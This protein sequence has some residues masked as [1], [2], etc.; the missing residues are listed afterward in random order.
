MLA[1]LGAVRRQDERP[2]DSADRA[3]VAGSV[4]EVLE[5]KILLVQVDVDY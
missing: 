2:E 1:E 5:L 3:V 4:A